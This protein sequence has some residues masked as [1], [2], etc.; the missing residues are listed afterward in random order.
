[1]GLKIKTLYEHFKEVSKEQVDEAIKSLSEK[2]R[3][4][5]MDRYG[6]DLENP[7][8]AIAW[9]KEKND[10]FYGNVYPRLKRILNIKTEPRRKK[11]KEVPST[12]YEVLSQYSKKEIDDAFNKLS[13]M[14]K[15]IIQ[16]R[17][18]EDFNV[19]KTTPFMTKL[20]KA[21]FKETIK[22][23]ESLI[24]TKP[25]VNISGV[26]VNVL[27]GYTEAEIIK[28]LSEL[29]ADER[30]FLTNPQH[31]KFKSMNQAQKQIY[32]QT[33]TYAIVNILSKNKE[34]V[35]EKVQDIKTEDNETL[36]TT[37]ESDENLYQ[38]QRLQKYLSNPTF[39]SELKLLS[40]KEITIVSLKYGLASNRCF[41]VDEIAVILDLPVENVVS[42]LREFLNNYKNKVTCAID[43][44]INT[45]IYEEGYCKKR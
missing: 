39:L 12:I 5:I 35:P 1:M 32:T 14:E 16:K 43:S 22:Q 17:Y 31:E 37:I 41:S 38:T 7:K 33:L 4:V 34:T 29:N 30:L 20:E 6:N 24:N 44:A 18:G 2:E 3:Q 21:S 13:T 15:F 23:L 10:Y 42:V 9:S 36:T 28:M 40:C 19:P 27:K 8:E 25:K 11:E 26:F 45:V